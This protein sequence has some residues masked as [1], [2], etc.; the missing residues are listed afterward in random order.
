MPSIVVDQRQVQVF[1]TASEPGISPNGDGFKDTETFNLI[2]KLRE[3]IDTW[4]FAVVDKDGAEKS[5]FCGK[6]N[7]VPNK[8]VWDGRDS[9]GAVV[10]GDYTGVF[11]VDY[12]KGDHAEARTGKI[13]VDIDAA[14]GPGEPDARPLQP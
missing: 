4:R 11:S 2:V 5:V 12:L 9:S 14:Q 6:G 7:D 1:V 13:L 3:G 10:Q 8:I